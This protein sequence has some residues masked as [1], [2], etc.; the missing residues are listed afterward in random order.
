MVIGGGEIY[1]QAFPLA[2]ILYLSAVDA[3][4]QG[5]TWFPEVNM[6]EWLE[7][8]RDT[9]PAQEGNRYAYAIRCLQ[10]KKLG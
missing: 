9:Y 8:S 6:N 3:E 5:D 2:D 10:R 1:Q 7:T 4:P